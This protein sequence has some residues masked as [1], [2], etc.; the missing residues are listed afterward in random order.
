LEGDLLEG[1][2]IL[3]DVG[4]HV[5]WTGELVIFTLELGGTGFEFKVVIIFSVEGFF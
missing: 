5:D 2:Y 1:A 3:F 4:E